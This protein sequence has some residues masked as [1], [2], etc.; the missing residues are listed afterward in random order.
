MSEH[1]ATLANWRQP[2]FNRRAFQHVRELIPTAAVPNDPAQVWALPEDPADL[3]DLA[4]AEADGTSI[5]VAGMLAATETDG[6]LVLHRGRIV[7]ED[8][9]HGLGAATPHIL[10]SVSKSVTGILAGVLVG[11]GQLDP[12]APVVRYLPEM[13]GSAYADASLRHLLDMTAG[14]AFEEDYLATGGVMLRYREAAGW[15]PRQAGEAP[16]DLHGFLTGLEE[17]IAPHGAA[18]RYVS[19]NVDLL[20]WVL[21]RASGQ[22]FADLL[23]EAIWRPMDAGREAYVTVDRLGA[24]RAAG[25]L[26]V[27]LRDLARFGR[28]LL[29]NG[30]RDGVEVVPA[31]WIS[32]LRQGGDPRAWA[33]GDSAD[34][35]PDWSLRY[36]SL[37]YVSGD[38]PFFGLGI[39]GQMLYVDPGHDLVVAKFS[40]QPDPVD[41]AKDR[42][43]LRAF[44]AIAEHLA[45]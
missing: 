28:L 14:A 2:P 17:R 26:C 22:R 25:G 4:F 1:Q 7:A 44:A 12:E 29:R 18:Y 42:M 37:W 38:G 35:F 10:M 19:P 13:A 6:F 39:H 41:D 34:T 16:L 24:A 45:G 33:L 32:D 27:T 3:M 31:A 43:A 11:R 20:G 30:A 5:T 9:R 23:S 8:Y 21:E 40:S 36:R 15:N